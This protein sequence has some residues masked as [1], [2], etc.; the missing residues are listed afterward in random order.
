MSMSDDQVDD[1]PVIR[2]VWRNVV[3][4]ESA[5][6]RV[7]EGNHYFPPQD[8]RPGYLR[9]SRLHTICPWKGIASYYDIVIDGATNRNA[10]WHYP[11]PFP[12][13]RK[14]KGHVAFWSGVDVREVVVKDQNRGNDARSR[15]TRR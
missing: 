2:A 9:R 8:V 11:H 7:V 6:T 3:L 15:T 14:I 13:A 5:D 10:A 1:R 4:A 12:L